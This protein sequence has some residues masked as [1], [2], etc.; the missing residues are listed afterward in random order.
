MTEIKLQLKPLNRYQFQ[1]F[2]WLKVS[3]R[4]LRPLD[5]NCKTC[6]I[7]DILLIQQPTNQDLNCFLDQR[8]M[9]RMSRIVI[10]WRLINSFHHPTLLNWIVNISWTE[11]NKSHFNVR[12]LCFCLFSRHCHF[13]SKFI[14]W[15]ETQ[16]IW[17][18][19]FRAGRNKSRKISF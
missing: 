5:L 9:N 10:V 4:N 18:E 1:D 6:N 16:I 8:K 7:L 12:W 11:S 3:Q 19:V 17:N 13:H 14:A 15:N 2:C